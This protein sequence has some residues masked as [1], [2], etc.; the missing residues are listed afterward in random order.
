MIYKSNSGTTIYFWNLICDITLFSCFTFDHNSFLIKL[1]FFP[2]V[3][4]L[5]CTSVCMKIC[6]HT[7]C[8]SYDT[9]SF[10]RDP[11]AT[12]PF[13]RDTVAFNEHICAKL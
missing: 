1:S 11:W 13:T 7:H 6:L 9:T 8:Y 3:K 12:C 10:K 5:Y 2:K 4:S